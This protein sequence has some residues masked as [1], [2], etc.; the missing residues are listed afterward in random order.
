[1]LVRPLL[2]IRN[3][4]RQQD[5]SERRTENIIVKHNK[6]LSGSAGQAFVDI[7]MQ[8]PDSKVQING[9]SKIKQNKRTEV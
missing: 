4:N 7:T 2:N 8:T 5:T 1:M 3:K 6:S 9:L